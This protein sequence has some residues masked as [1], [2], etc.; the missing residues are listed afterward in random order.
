MQPGSVFKIVQNVC[1]ETLKYP[2]IRYR[3]VSL[4]TFLI[5]DWQ[6]KDKCESAML[7]VN[8]NCYKN[9]KGSK[10]ESGLCDTEQFSFVK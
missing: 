9:K 1:I 10:V 6:L 8:K 4:K 2:P 5:I 7:I 3:L